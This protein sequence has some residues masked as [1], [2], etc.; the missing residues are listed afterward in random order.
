MS[1]R[2]A[3]DTRPVRPVDPV[4]LARLVRGFR[5]TRTVS[6]GL[7]LAL[8]E[9]ARGVWERRRP[10]DDREDFAQ[11]CYL[12][13]SGRPLA[14]A[15]PNRN[16]FAYFVTCAARYGSKLR[17]KAAEERRKFERYAQALADSGAEIPA[18][19]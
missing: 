10:T 14:K 17:N 16:L 12:Y 13:L 9:I 11:A 8:A 6:E 18:A 19:D 7:A 2:V 3:A 4:A 15:D 1:D 5:R